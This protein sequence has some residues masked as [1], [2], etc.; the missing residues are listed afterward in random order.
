[1][2]RLGTDA[3]VDLARIRSELATN[4][5]P[6]ELPA[7]L[8]PT[9]DAD[10]ERRLAANFGRLHRLFAELAGRSRAV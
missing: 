5:Q 6:A 1:M 8:P 10:F 2:A 4:T 9:H 7:V 3:A